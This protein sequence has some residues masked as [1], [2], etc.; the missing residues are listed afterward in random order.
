MPERIYHTTKHR[1]A[2]PITGI[3]LNLLERKVLLRRELL[4]ECDR[5]AVADSA[6]V[7]AWWS[8]RS[9]RDRW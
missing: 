5:R 2:T 3:A 6:A 8:L 1:G 7:E 4:I 9:L